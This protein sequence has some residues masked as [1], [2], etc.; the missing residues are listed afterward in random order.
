MS[1]FRTRNKVCYKDFIE[2]LAS[3]ITSIEN[4]IEKMKEKDKNKEN[5]ENININ[6][7]PAANN[8]SLTYRKPLKKPLEK[9]AK[10][11]D[12]EIVQ[13]EKQELINKIQKLRKNNN[14]IQDKLMEYQSMNY[15]LYMNNNNR[16]SKTFTPSNN[17]SMKIN[18]FIKQNICKKGNDDVI[19]NIK[20]IKEEYDYQILKQAFIEN[21]YEDFK[22]FRV[23][24]KQTSTNVYEALYTFVEK[25]AAYKSDNNSEYKKYVQKLL[26]ENH[27]T[28]IKQ[29]SH[30]L[31]ELH[32]K[33]NA[34]SE[35]EVKLKEN[36]LPSKRMR[37]FSNDNQRHNNN[38]MCHNSYHISL[39]KMDILPTMDY[40]ML[41][42]L[43][44]TRTPGRSISPNITDR[45]KK[46][47]SRRNRFV[48][49]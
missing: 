28:D 41:E 40:Y 19:A 14:Q 1:T 9:K 15:K 17:S 23:T 42:N 12:I 3:R 36:G 10:I 43:N 20:N 13:K 2:K 22:K 38:T 37:C 25:L 48:Y 5:K 31:K 26:T 6:Q 45:T 44:A 35:Y 7:Y 30:L 4:E 32:R 34:M 39:S 46:I 8:F 49:A 33:K 11:D 29:L 24:N 18:N 16:L 27:L 21:L 47:L